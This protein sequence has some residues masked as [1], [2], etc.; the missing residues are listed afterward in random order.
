MQSKVNEWMDYLAQQNF[1]RVDSFIQHKWRDTSASCEGLDCPIYGSGG[2]DK[3]GQE[4]IKESEFCLVVHL[5]FGPVC[6][7]ADF[8][9]FPFF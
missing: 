9:P 6:F 2:L 3:V 4:G 1:S 7:F 8:F 5:R